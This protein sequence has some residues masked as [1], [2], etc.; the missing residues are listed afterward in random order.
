[1]LQISI[2][3][4][5]LCS[6]I[7]CAGIIKGGWG[8]GGGDH[9]HGIPIFYRSGWFYSKHFINLSLIAAIHQLSFMAAVS[10]KT[11]RTG[12]QSNDVPWEKESSVLTTAIRVIWYHRGNMPVS[13]WSHPPAEAQLV[14]LLYRYGY[15]SCPLNKLDA[16]LFQ[17]GKII[18][19]NSQLNKNS[20]LI[21]DSKHAKA[22]STTCH[23]WFRWIHIYSILR[24]HQYSGGIPLGKTA[25]AFYVS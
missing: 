8:W 9:L 12:S 19:L 16:I 7:R 21:P 5:S 24:C 3:T 6:Y 14:G 22:K 4:T 10:G 18:H 25:T 2:S 17:E 15:I 11:D 23:F 20:T 13:F 1:M